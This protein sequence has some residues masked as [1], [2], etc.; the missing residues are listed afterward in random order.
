MSRVPYATSNGAASKR[1]ECYTGWLPEC[2]SNVVHKQDRSLHAVGDS[3]EI[4]S[5][6]AWPRKRLPVARDC[7]HNTHTT[8]GWAVSTMWGTY[9]RPAVRCRI[10]IQSC[11]C[12]DALR[13]QEGSMQQKNIL[14][15]SRRR[16]VHTD[17]VLSTLR[18][19]MFRR[20][21]PISNTLS[22]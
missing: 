11:S 8:H 21:A 1:I 3:D 16:P 19:R 4:S 6:L 7:D 20:G 10:F 12:F 2:G 9:R 15:I 22:A 18:D 14:S 5:M 17:A 13:S